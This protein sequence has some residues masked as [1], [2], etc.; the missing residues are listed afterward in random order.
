M[1][2]ILSNEQMEC[3]ALEGTGDCIDESHCANCHVGE[4]CND[5]GTCEEC[6]FERSCYLADKMHDEMKVGINDDGKRRI[7]KVAL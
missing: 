2:P 5:D 4:G 1:K 3:P 7:R 6:S